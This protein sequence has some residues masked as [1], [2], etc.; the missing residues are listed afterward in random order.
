MVEAPARKIY[1]KIAGMTCAS[2]VKRVEDALKGLK[3]VSEASVNLA[4]EKAAIAYDPMKVSI[5]DMIS[6]VKDAGYGVVTETATLPVQGMTCASCV[7]RVED[8]LREK[9]GVI[10]VS[11]NLATER[12]TVRYNPE[13]ATLPGLKKAIIEAGYTVP[14]IK[15]EREFVD[16]EREARRREM[17]DLTEKFVLSGIAAAAIM[18]L[19]FLR[20]YIPIISSLPHEWVMYI[21]FLLATP[22]QFWI[23]WRFYKGAYAA[24]KHGTADMNVLIAVGTSA[25]YFYSVIATFAPRLVAIGGE[26][27]ATY[28]D[29]STMIIALILLGRLLE[30]RAKGRTSEAI[31]R[32]TGLQARTA[33]VIRDSREEEVLVEDVKVGDIVVVRPGEKIPVDGVVIDG[34][35]SVDESMITGEPIPASKKAGDNVIGATI[36]KTGSFKFRATKVGRD[37]VL[38]QIIKMVEEAQGTKAPIQRLADRVA[39]VFVPIVMALAI[40]TFLAWYFLGPQPAFLMA[41]LNFISVLIIACPCAM[42]LATPTAIMV[43]TGKG[44]QYGILI[45]GGESLENA[46]KINTIVLDKTGTITKGKPSLVDVEPVP[47]FSVSEIIRFAASAEKGSEHPLGEAIVKDAQERGIPLT[48]ATKF[49]AIPGKGVVAEVEGHIVMVGNSS[50]MEYEEVPLD[51]MEGAFERLSAEGKT[52]MYVSVDGKPAGV[53]AVADTIKEG[54]REAIAELKKLGIEAIMVTG[55]NRRTAE[56]IARQVGIE[57]VMAEVLPQ[58]K[59]E[60][61]R[62][63][64]SDGRIVAMVGDGIN[65]A[66]ALAQADTGIAIGTGTD[67]AIE[68]SDITLMSGDLRG[69]VTAIKLSRATIRTIRMNLF[70]A[71]IYNIIGIPIAAG[72]LYPWL[73]LLLNPIIAAA[74]MAFSSV[75]VVSNSLLLNRF[76]P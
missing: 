48:E 10:D 63:L 17:S 11:V 45:K 31:R 20:P 29:T 69:V 18:A 28:Y 44:A 25:A 7:K 70:W 52:P 75:S 27:P 41:L 37:T 5:D 33:R 49:D 72:V 1:L 36:N 59:A 14:E 54:S 68:S 71:F 64:Q 76:K 39:A 8:A 15:A 34:Y 65:D 67:I 57:K 30:A 35:S 56:A 74:A 4:N 50:L 55:D 12:V 43:G 53:V 61:V 13:E 32:L 21:S 22:V 24:L 40:L 16:V 19:M 6:A 46:H 23:G 38:S 47:G 66:P 51:E 60:V 73:H 62:K 9:Q 26:M 2:C 42:G 58:D 3:G